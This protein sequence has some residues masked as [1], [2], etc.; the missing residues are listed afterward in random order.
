MEYLKKLREERYAED[1]TDDIMVIPPEEFGDKPGYDTA[2]FTFFA[3]GVVADEKD[4]VVT[5]LANT[6]G[7][8]SLNHFGEY[9]EDTVFVRNC[10]KEMDY[11]ILRDLRTYS[12]A[13]KYASYPS[14]GIFSADPFD[15]IKEE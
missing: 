12:E 6:I 2:T 1:D 15:I 7:L 5:D 3:D 4:D 10:I 14:E 13:L 8:E 11:E 9:E